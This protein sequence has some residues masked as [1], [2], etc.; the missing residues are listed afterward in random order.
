MDQDFKNQERI[1]EYLQGELKGANLKAFQEDLK[2]DAQLQEDLAFSQAMMTTLKNKEIVAANH[3]L[4]NSISGKTLEPDFEALKEYEKTINNSGSSSSS[5]WL[6][7]GMLGLSV[8]VIGLLASGL[9]SPFTSNEPTNPLVLPHLVPFENVIRASADISPDL[10]KGM[11][12]YENSNYSGAISSLSTYLKDSYDPNVQF[13]LGLAHLLNEEAAVAVPLLERV[14]DTSE[15][16]ILTMSKWY[17][18]LAYIEDG[19]IPAAKVILQELQ[20]NPDFADKATTL[21]NDLNN[22]PL[23]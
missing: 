3:Q 15:P 8:L 18:T 17:L 9:F 11:A 2:N 20:T 14:V 19:Q 22:Q 6:L 4:N 5:K 7:G 23:Q 12:A 21:L 16:P 10:E 13:Y 1:H